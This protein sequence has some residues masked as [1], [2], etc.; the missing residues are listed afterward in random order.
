MVNI[1]RIPGS[2]G[3]IILTFTHIP[4]DPCM[5]YI[6]IYG[7]IYHQYTPNVSIYIPYMDPMG[8]LIKQ[9]LGPVS[10]R[11]R[12]SPLIPSIGPYLFSIIHDFLFLGLSTTGWWFGTWNS[13]FHLQYWEF[14]HPNWRTH[15]FQKGRYTTNQKN[16]VLK[17]HL[18]IIIWREI[19][20]T[21]WAYSVYFPHFFWR[22]FCWE[23]VSHKKSLPK[24]P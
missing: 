19:V 18:L 7:N 17:I 11:L 8:I 6:Y 10:P 14:H 23:H 9:S 16:M 22:L 5:L 12:I 15:I 21:Y 1:S 3:L 2:T 24:W 4:W 20:I 13:C